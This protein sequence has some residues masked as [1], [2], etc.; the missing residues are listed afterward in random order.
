M[1]S[2]AKKAA[3]ERP[4]PKTDDDATTGWSRVTARDI[5]EELGILSRIHIS[6]PTRPY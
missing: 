1:T 6:E 2:I 5:A 3:S 4:A